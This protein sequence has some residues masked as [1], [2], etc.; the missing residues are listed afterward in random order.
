MNRQNRFFWSPKKI[1]CQ[2]PSSSK[3]VDCASKSN[4]PFGHAFVK[5]R[6]RF[7]RMFFS[8][9]ISLQTTPRDGALETQPLTIK[10]NKSISAAV[11]GERTPAHFDGDF[12]P[13]QIWQKLDRCAERHLCTWHAVKCPICW[14]RRFHP[15]EK[16]AGI[17]YIGSI[18][19]QTLLIAAS[20]PSKHS[21]PTNKKW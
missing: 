6:S 1:I 21:K 20:H 13:L 10:R 14:G 7:S 15:M 11:L 19:H 16:K 17:T 3:V 18:K 4:V 2:S 9:N 8:R 12:V 5:S